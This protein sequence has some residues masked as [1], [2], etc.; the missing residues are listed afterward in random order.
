MVEY[1]CQI[2]ITRP[3]IKETRESER[4]PEGGESI[5]ATNQIDT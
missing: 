5:V 1:T 2:K 4:E 3:I